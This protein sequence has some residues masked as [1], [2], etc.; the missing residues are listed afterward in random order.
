MKQSKGTRRPAKAEAALGK[1]RR[2]PPRSLT[3][4]LAFCA[5]FAL[6][7]VLDYAMATALPDE[8]DPVRFYAVELGDDLRQLYVKAIDGAR[9][10][11]TLCVYGLSDEGVIH[12][13][14]RAYQRDVAVRIAC[15]R[16]ASQGVHRK[17]ARGLKVTYHRD[18]GLMHLKLLIVDGNLVVLGSANMTGDSLKR[19]RN[20]VGAFYSK[21][22]ASLLDEALD[23]PL[24]DGHFLAVTPKKTRFAAAGQNAE[25]Y[26]TPSQSAVARLLELIATA[27]KSI[28]VAM[29]TF[30]RQDLAAQLVAARRRGVDVE[31]FVDYQSAQGS[32]REVALMLQREGVTLR[33]GPSDRLLHHK[34]MVIDDRCC[35]MGSAN[36]TKAAFSNNSDCLLLLHDLSEG[37]QGTLQAMWKRLERE[38]Q[39][40][41][42]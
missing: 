17:L 40:L 42:Q 20:L 41:P 23:S 18:P 5:A 19:H 39:P 12:A 29:Y 21:G 38:S 1:G 31:V 37:Q 25:L 24:A 11:V 9:E 32:S 16:T 14:N 15:D 8:D 33:A 28:K 36:W 26:L 3:A 4:L 22:L 34:F 2:L 13:L 35:A 30:T 27:R 7:L 6:F 10:R